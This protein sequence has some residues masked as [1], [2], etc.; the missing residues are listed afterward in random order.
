[1]DSSKGQFRIELTPEQKAK[2]RDATGTDAEAVE[3]SV[4][5]LEERIAPAYKKPPK[6]T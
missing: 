2:V 3:L 6:F 4:E 5:E 1:M